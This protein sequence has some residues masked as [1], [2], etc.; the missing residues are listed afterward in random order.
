AHHDIDEIDIIAH[1]RDGD[2]SDDR[3]HNTR[4]R[5]GAEAELTRL[6]LIDLD[7]NLSRWFDPV[8]VDVLRFWISR[9]DLGELEGNLPH[10]IEVGTSDT[11]LYWPSDGRSELERIDPCHDFRKILRQNLLELGVQ[12]FPRL[13]IFSHDH[14]LGEEIVR[15]LHVE[16]QIETNSPL[17]DIGAPPV[18]IRI[19]L[20]ECV[21]PL[22]Q[23]L[24]GMDRRILPQGQIDKKLRPIRGGKKLLR[25]QWKRKN[26]TNEKS[27]DED[28]CQPFSPDSSDKQ[29][30]IHSQQPALLLL[31]RFWWLQN[32][33]A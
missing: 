14:C 33:D 20:Q 6:V 18:D 11:I 16:R 26:R 13:D 32:E 1:L 4:Q 24:A 22:R 9:D 27:D 19:I 5:I 25:D 17:A 28:D 21:E 29:A 7:A 8:E 15:Q 10:L 31:S 30:A 2:A 3:V 23:A 12:T